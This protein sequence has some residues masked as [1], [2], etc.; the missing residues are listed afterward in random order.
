VPD[1]VPAAMQRPVD[2]YSGPLVQGAGFRDIFLLAEASAEARPTPR[3]HP[4]HRRCFGL[5]AKALDNV[6]VLF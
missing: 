4:T 6:P 2:I 5:K 1:R 3:R